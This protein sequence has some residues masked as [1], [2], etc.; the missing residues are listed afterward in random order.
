VIGDQ[1]VVRVSDSGRW[2]VPTLPT[3]RGRGI[4]FMRELMSDVEIR[5]T[6]GGTEVTLRRRLPE[7][8]PAESTRV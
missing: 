5:E 7:L 1:L 4:S 6:A 2:R 3:D 8:L